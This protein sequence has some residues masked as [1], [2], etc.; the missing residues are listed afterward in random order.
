MKKQQTSKPTPAPLTLRRETL[1]QLAG[2]ELAGAVGGVRIWKPVGFADD[3]TPI[4]EE[5]DI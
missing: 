3:T 4:Y 2:A 1:R 5:V